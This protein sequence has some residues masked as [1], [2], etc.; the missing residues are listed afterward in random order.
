MITLFATFFVHPTLLHAIT[1]E[2]L[3]QMEF[4][5]EATYIIRLTNGD[6]LSGPIVETSS[7]AGGAFVRI[8]ASIGR[9]KI[10]AKEIDS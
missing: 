1:D 6:M 10:Y 9:A 4:F 5:D 3:S 7:D 2:A 8:G